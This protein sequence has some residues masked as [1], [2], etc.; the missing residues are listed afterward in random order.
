MFRSRRPTAAPMGTVTF[1]SRRTGEE[2]ARFEHQ[3]RRQVDRLLAHP[4]E[5]ASRLGC[6][7]EVDAAGE[8]ARR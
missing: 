8:R 7:V 3:S 5:V 4:P 2:L 6:T 1:R